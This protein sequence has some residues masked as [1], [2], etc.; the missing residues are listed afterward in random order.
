MYFEFSKSRSHSRELS[1]QT[2]S[3]QVQNGPAGQTALLLGAA[4]LV[5]VTLNFIASFIRCLMVSQF[6]SIWCIDTYLVILMSNSSSW[7]SWDT[8][9]KQIK[10]LHSRKYVLHPS[11]AKQGHSIVDEIVVAHA[12]SLCSKCRA[13]R[14][15]KLGAQSTWKM[16]GVEGIL[17]SWL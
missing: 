9:V 17:Q 6:R 10:C 12:L 4:V 16:Q 3:P 8:F 11:L 1:T 13:Y 15:Q 7:A 2:R 5:I 14:T